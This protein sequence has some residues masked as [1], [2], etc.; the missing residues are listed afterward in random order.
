MNAPTPPVPS[1]PTPPGGVGD[2]LRILRD[3][4]QQ[5]LARLEA[6]IAAG[7]GD[8]RTWHN[9]AVGRANLE[10][11]EGALVAVG[12]AREA[13][14][15]SAITHYL[16]G[17]LL[18]A[19]GR[20]AD[21]LQA[22][23]VVARCDSGF[24]RLA[25]QRGVAHFFLGEVEAARR[26][27]E[28]AIEED[29][30]DTVARFN[31]AV[32]A[33]ALHDFELA[34]RTLEDLIAREPEN[35]SRTCQLL[36]ELGGAQ[37]V[38]ET[39][40]QTHRIK[41]FLG[42]VG[43]RLRRFV[44]STLECP[45][46]LSGEQREDLLAIRDDYERVYGDLVVF[47]RAIQP[48]PMK[49][50]AIDLRRL[51]DRVVFV[52]SHRAQGTKVERHYASELPLVRCDLDALQE[53]FLNLLLNAFDAVAE[54]PDRAGHVIVSA[55]PAGAHVRVS[56]TDN[57][58]GIA[59]GNLARVFQFGFT[60]KGLGTGIGLSFTRRV[61]EEHGGTVLIESES[62][63]GTTIHCQLPV[64]PVISESLANRSLRVHLFQ[65]L[66]ELILQE[67]DELGI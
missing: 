9:L 31:L 64:A 60:T 36:V 21:A 51:L 8:Y 58:A 12:R 47:L 14:P 23:D 29:P 57:G 30:L 62:G 22:Y 66:R 27:F 20:P 26:E 56:V 3:A 65:D 6:R 54:V 38:Q 50:A 24:R 4:P 13:A 61:V 5:A 18:Q 15:A 55:Q 43:D 32:I 53:A 34:R 16:A 67:D 42:I 1:A 41:N 63:Q 35:A 39:L 49:L 46:A 19:A 33:V 48:R 25:A 40:T 17:K 28:R 44:E 2:T 59:P 7:R 10:D 45:D 52:A 37:V 11:L